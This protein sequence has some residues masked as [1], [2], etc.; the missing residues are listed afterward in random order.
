VAR[1]LL[2]PRANLEM[3]ALILLLYQR[4]WETAHPEWTLR[5]RPD[6]LATLY[7]IGFSRSKPHAAPRS[8]AFGTRVRAVYEEA[9]LAE[10]WL[11]EVLRTNPV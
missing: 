9:W 3:C 1:A 2:D 4:Q 8:N 10:A 7:Q 5:A 6:I 11:A